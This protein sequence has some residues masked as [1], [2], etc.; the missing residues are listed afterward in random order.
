[1]TLFVNYALKLTVLQEKPLTAF[2]IATLVATVVSYVLSRE[3]AFSTRGGREQHHEAALFFM[4]NAVAIG[5]TLVPDAIA[6]YVLLL[7]VPHVS[8]AVQ[9]T[10]DFVADFIVG[11]LLGT[12]CRWWGY[13]KL[14][15]P[16]ADARPRRGKVTAL[17]PEDAR[18]LPQNDEVA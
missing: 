11:V 14:V 1:V 16:Q 6:R 5:L 18:H 2:G 7:E 9:E 10:S 13:K 15:F 12:A 3:W 8:F 4:V 17:R